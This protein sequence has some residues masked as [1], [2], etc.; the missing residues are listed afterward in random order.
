M[1]FLILQVFPAT[2]ARAESLPLRV[3]VLFPKSCS[4][5]PE[6]QSEHVT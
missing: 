3:L 6:C 1:N 5:E 4:L 2:C